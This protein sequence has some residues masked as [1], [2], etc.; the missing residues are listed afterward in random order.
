M[1]H[2]EI[3]VYYRECGSVFKKPLSLYSILII[4]GVNTV[5]LALPLVTTASGLACGLFSPHNV[6]VPEKTNDKTA[7][8]SVLILM[9]CQYA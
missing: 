9:I 8:T 5:N 1:R 4:S 3:T 2:S 7:N 6:I